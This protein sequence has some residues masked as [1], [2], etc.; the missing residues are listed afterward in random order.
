MR[1]ADHFNVCL[2]GF[3]SFSSKRDDV[4]QQHEFHKL[5]CILRLARDGCLTVGAGVA[6]NLDNV[7]VGGVLAQSAHDV[8][9]LVVGHL[10]VTNSVKETKS[11]LEVWS[12][13]GRESGENFEFQLI[14]NKG[15]I[16]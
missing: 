15:F 11:L 16:S 12:G 4:T 10:A 1:S 5:F 6:Q 2:D 9:H 13:G 7:L 8:G 14:R 3:L